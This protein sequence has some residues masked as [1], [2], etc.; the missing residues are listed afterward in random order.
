MHVYGRRW[1]EA[2]AFGRRCHRGR[3]R[4]L[5][6]CDRLGMQMHALPLGRTGA[7]NERVATRFRVIWKPNCCNL[8]SVQ[9]SLPFFFVPPPRLPPPRLPPTRREHTGT[10]HKAEVAGT[11]AYRCAAW[12]SFTVTEEGME[13]THT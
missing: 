13:E 10:K 8:V 6:S 12:L 3:H 11:L 1:L 7:Q 2:A 4:Y 5:V 9:S